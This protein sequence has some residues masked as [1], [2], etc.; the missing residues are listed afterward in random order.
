MLLYI[1]PDLGGITGAPKSAIDVLI[2]L[3]ATGEPVT[4]MSHEAC[5]LPGKVNGIILGSPEWILLSRTT[6]FPHQLNRRFPKHVSAWIKSKLQE[7]RVSRWLRSITPDLIILNGLGSHDFW[8]RLSWPAH[9]R[10]V[11]IVRESVGHF[12]PLN[13][14][15]AFKAMKP[16]PSL[17]FVSSRCRDEWQTLGVLANKKT[18]YIPNCCQE[19]AVAHLHKQDRAQ[20]RWRLGLPMDKLVAVCVASLQRRKGQDILLDQLSEIL[21]VVPDLVIYFVGPIF[22]WGGGEQIHERIKKNRFRSLLKV[23]GARPDALDFIYAADLLVLP[24]RAEAM[25]RVILEAMALKTPVIASDVGGIPE[26]IEHEKTGLL[27]SHHN[28]VELVD[29][30]AYMAANPTTRQTFAE[31]AYQK[32]WSTFSR[33][34]QMKKYHE[35]L[36]RLLG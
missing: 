31:C 34:H 23:T 17:I 33:A 35:M 3:L 25:P 32:Y 2:N 18:F 8:T 14:D 24:A 5:E 30:F 10:S 11:M 29:A 22:P 20:V 4:V 9:K 13:I 26:L 12:T 1:A 6:S 21:A 28:P 15:F 27:F 16:H 7:I 36:T 19:D